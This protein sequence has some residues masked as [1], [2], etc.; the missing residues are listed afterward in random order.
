MES[1]KRNSM[2]AVCGGPTSYP[3]AKQIKPE[4]VGELDLVMLTEKYDLSLMMLRRALRWSLFDM[5][6]RRMKS[7]HADDLMKATAT[8]VDYLS[9]PVGELN[10]ATRDYLEAC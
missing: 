5:M 8:F 3:M 1:L 9:Q 10:T 6:Y 4:Q 7:E 2:P